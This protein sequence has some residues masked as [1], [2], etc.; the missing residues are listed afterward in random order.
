[1]SLLTFF[2]VLMKGAILTVGFVGGGNIEMYREK[3]NESQNNE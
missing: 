3:E 2:F 1:M